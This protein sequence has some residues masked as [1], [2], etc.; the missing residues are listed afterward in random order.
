MPLWEFLIQATSSTISWWHA[1]ACTRF[2]IFPP[3]AT[4]TP[5]SHLLS[6]FRRGDKSAGLNLAVLVL[7]LSLL[8]CSTSS[9]QSVFIME[10]RAWMYSFS[11]H[12]RWWFWE[13]KCR[14]WSSRL[15]EK[16]SSFKQ[17][18]KPIVGWPLSWATVLFSAL[19]IELPVY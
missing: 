15:Y 18:L 12:A 6:P 14:H 4:N 1:H 9:S 16:W 17:N 19:L 10:T 3:A 8:S 7:E 13:M 2:C 5:Q 11:L